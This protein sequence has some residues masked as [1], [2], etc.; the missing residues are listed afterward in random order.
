MKELFSEYVNKPQQLLCGF[1]VANITFSNNLKCP[2]ACKSQNSFESTNIKSIYGYGASF[3]G[4]LRE[5]CPNTEFFLVRMWEN[6]DHKK[7]LIWTLFTQWLP[8]L[9]RYFLP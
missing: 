2:H 8:P 9:Q 1:L 4:S 3:K 5:K 7:L 6:T